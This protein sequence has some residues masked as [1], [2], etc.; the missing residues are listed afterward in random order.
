MVLASDGIMDLLTNREVINIV[1]SAPKRSVA[2]KLLVNHAARAWKYKY[3]FKVDYCSSIC[4][5]LKD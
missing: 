3:G 1:A 2:A 5:F 4:L